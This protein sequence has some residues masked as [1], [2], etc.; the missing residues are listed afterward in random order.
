MS[1][2]NAKFVERSFKVESLCWVPD[3]DVFYIF[4]INFVNLGYTIFKPSRLEYINIAYVL[5]HL[6]E[7]TN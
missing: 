4:S 7:I 6:Q 1:K 3:F 2:K 5:E